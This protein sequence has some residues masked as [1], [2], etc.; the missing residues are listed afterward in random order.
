M[1]PEGAILGV[2]VGWVGVRLGVKLGLRV[3][4]RLGVVDG[5]TVGCTDDGAGVGAFVI[6]NE[7]LDGMYNT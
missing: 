4:V 3:G 1:G 5:C 2:T 6:K 7:I